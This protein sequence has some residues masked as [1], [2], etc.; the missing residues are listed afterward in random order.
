LGLIAFASGLERYFLRKTT[1]LETILFW[2]AAAGL[3]WPEYW[4][5]VAG[6]IALVCAVVLQKCYTPQKSPLIAAEV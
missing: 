4:A 3:F 2:L 1:W 6:F 5:D